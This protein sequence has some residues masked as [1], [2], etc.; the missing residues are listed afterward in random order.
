MWAMSKGVFQKNWWK[1]S[2]VLFTFSA[3][4]SKIERSLMFRR[5]NKVNYEGKT[6]RNNVFLKIV[7]RRSPSNFVSYQVPFTVAN[8]SMTCSTPGIQP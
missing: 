2:D 3:T 8:W 6:H 1:R 5:S 7:L 4:Q